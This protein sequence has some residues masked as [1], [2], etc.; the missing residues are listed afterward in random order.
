MSF[1]KITF[2]ENVYQL[3]EISKMTFQN[4]CQRDTAAHCNTLQ[5]TATHCNTLQHTATHCN[6]LQHPAAHCITL[7]RTAA[8]CNA[9]QRTA[10]PWQ[11]FSKVF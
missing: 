9:L 7:Q 2:E 6:T 8:H 4:V 5:F 3:I 1:S 10:T 11:K